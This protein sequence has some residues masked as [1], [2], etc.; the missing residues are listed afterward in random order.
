L[1]YHPDVSNATGTEEK[2]QGIKLAYETLRIPAK[3]E[4]YLKEHR[5][6]HSTEI[7]RV[8]TPANDDTRRERPNE[9]EFYGFSNFF[10]DLVKD[11]IQRKKSGKSKTMWEEL[12][13]LGEEIVGDLLDM[14]EGDANNFSKD[15]KS[16]D[17]IIRETPLYEKN[18]YRVKRKKDVAPTGKTSCEGESNRSY[19]QEYLQELEEKEKQETEKKR[20]RESEIDDELASLK[21]KLES[22]DGS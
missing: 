17:D 3:R 18:P 15:T 13:S 22:S 7:V 11:E 20:R 5:R 14:L 2:F 21:R 6:V 16:A 1:K 10:M 9:E 8:N 12:G 4:A 19:Y